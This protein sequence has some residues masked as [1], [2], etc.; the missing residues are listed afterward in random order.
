M[1][2]NGQPL[3]A[4]PSMLFYDESVAGYERLSFKS[5]H[6]PLAT[7]MHHAHD[8]CDMLHKRSE[9][10]INNVENCKHAQRENCTSKQS[11]EEEWLGLSLMRKI[12][13]IDSDVLAS[14][15]KSMPAPS[16]RH[17]FPFDL[18]SPKRITLAKVSTLHHDQNRSNSKS[19]VSATKQ[20]QK[21]GH[22]LN[23][24]ECDSCSPVTDIN[25]AKVN[26]DPEKTPLS[27][28]LLKFAENRYSLPSS[29][30][31]VDIEATPSNKRVAHRQARMID[32][33]LFQG[34]T[35]KEIYVDN[36]STSTPSPVKAAAEASSRRL[37]WHSPKRSPR[38]SWLHNVLMRFHSKQIRK[39]KQP[40]ARK[41]HSGLGGCGIN[42]LQYSRDDMPIDQESTTPHEPE[43]RPATSRM[44]FGFDGVNDDRNNKPLPL[45][46]AQQR[47][48]PSLQSETQRIFFD[49][50][51][52][53][54][55]INSSLHSA[56]SYV[57][58]LRDKGDLRSLVSATMSGPHELSSKDSDLNYRYS[59][60]SS[61]TAPAS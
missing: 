27:Q 57:F 8:I 32:G 13:S 5:F 7:P 39:S 38:Q 36:H 20:E 4:P 25:I 59:S 16:R 52:D 30:G 60:S 1:L 3:Q 58:H 10:D 2:K 42:E 6:V 22:S 46:P 49:R 15:R 45:S 53:E 47:Y 41:H 61:L 50:S 23:R 37:S 51:T 44:D 56:H 14:P 29:L 40:K 55:G 26:E 35:R 17:H 48:T 54:D 24:E 31:P 18:V 12:P 34:K 33:A 43:T 28:R 11:S 19:I 9:Q 21:E